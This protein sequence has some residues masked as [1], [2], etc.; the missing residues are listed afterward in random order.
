V[1]RDPVP[2]AVPGSEPVA[3]LTAVDD[4]GRADAVTEGG[5]ERQSVAGADAH[6]RDAH[7]RRIRPRLPLEKRQGC[8]GVRPEAVERQLAARRLDAPPVLGPQGHGEPQLA[9]AVVEVGQQHAV[10]PRRDL[11]GEIPQRLPDSGV[12]HVEEHARLRARI[13]GDDER[14]HRAVASLDLHALSA[15]A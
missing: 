3:V 5:D 15:H 4:R 1:G 6:S 14:L 8:L 12:V 2:K 7:A 13:R 10:A 11:A 9:L